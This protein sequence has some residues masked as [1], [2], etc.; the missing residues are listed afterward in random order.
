MS[1][2]A[3]ATSDREMPTFF[4]AGGQDL[5][6]ILTQPVGDPIGTAIILLPSGGRPLAV[7]RNRFSVRLARRLGGLGYHVMRFDYHGAGESA[8]TVDRFRLDRPFVADVEGAVTWLR[9][10]GVN[11]FILLGVCFGARTALS[12]APRV[13]G[14][15]GLIL[16]SPPV[17]DIQMG[18]RH[19][20]RAARDWSSWQ[21]LRRGIRPEA[22]RGLT[23]RKRRGQ[24]AKFARAKWQ[25]LVTRRRA[26]SEW[27]ST[28]V[29]SG[30][31]LDPLD[32]IVEKRAPVLFLFGED[33][34]LFQDFRRA[35]EGPLGRILER[36]DD[37]VRLEILPGRVHG[38]T[39]LETQDRVQERVLAWCQERLHRKESRSIST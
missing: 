35:Q 18:T 9:G 16:I 6:G 24:Y 29:V 17:R 21:Y 11:R 37:L 30:K 14:L 23:R 5:F 38:F 2:P 13:A 34:D 12:T 7:S 1:E 36:A 15:Q 31:F 19:S 8:G 3:A 27:Q 20:T 22:L 28:Y 32:R 10:R 4:P 25:A 39:R 26:P 33:E